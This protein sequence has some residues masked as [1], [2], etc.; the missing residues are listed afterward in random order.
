LK[1]NILRKEGIK[2]GIPKPPPKR[3]SHKLLSNG[4]GMIIIKV[5]ED[6]NRGLCPTEETE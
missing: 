3:S 1:G 6:K 4:F 5:L 2:D